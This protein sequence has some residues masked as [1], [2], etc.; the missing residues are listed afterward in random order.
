MGFSDRNTFYIGN[1]DTVRE[2][3]SAKLR[4]MVERVQA[5]RARLDAAE[6][7]MSKMLVEEFGVDPV[8]A[9]RMVGDVQC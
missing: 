3:H 9:D 6:L 4:K 5:A 8:Y 1:G 7:A 2:V